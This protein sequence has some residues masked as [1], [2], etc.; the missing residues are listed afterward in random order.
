MMGWYGGGFPGG[1]MMILG[2]ITMLL[3]VVGLVVLVAW[4]ARKMSGGEPR[5]NREAG[6]WAGGDVA[7]A[8][9]R[10]RYAAGE[11][12]RE[13]FERMRADLE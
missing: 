3:V 7:L 13:E 10:R 8:T 11:I 5:P 9:L 12:S 6:E 1:G 4:A 2:W